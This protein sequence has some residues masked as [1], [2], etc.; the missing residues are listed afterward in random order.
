VIVRAGARGRT[1][2]LFF[3]PIRL[4]GPLVSLALF[5]LVVVLVAPMPILAR[6][7]RLHGDV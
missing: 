1:A 2:F 6:H 4:V 7:R 5:E 3:E